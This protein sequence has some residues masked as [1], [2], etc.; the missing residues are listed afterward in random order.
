M[1]VPE[2]ESSSFSLGTVMKQLA[3]ALILAAGTAGQG[4]SM[5][6]VVSRA[7]A[8][9]ARRSQFFGAICSLVLYIAG[10]HIG[11]S[12]LVVSEQA[13]VTEQRHDQ[14]VVGLQPATRPRQ[15]RLV[16][17]SRFQ[18]QGWLQI[19]AERHVRAVLV[20]CRV[21]LE[22]LHVNP[23]LVVGREVLLW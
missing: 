2:Y 23:E 7:Q 5:V 18:P 3:G 12:G 19:K 8:Q 22:W 4:R 16:H 9:G 14:R 1:R 10:R 11:E 20:E 15:Q 17:V 21:G 13:G 6:S